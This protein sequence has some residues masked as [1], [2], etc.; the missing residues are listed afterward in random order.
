MRSVLLFMLKLVAMP[1]SWIGMAV[2]CGGMVTFFVGL[3]FAF[4]KPLLLA[5]VVCSGGLIAAAIGAW[6][7]GVTSALVDNIEEYY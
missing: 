4:F 3:F 6:V 7:C 1:I 2:S 5:A